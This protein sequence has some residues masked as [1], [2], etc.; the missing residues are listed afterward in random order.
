MIFEEI[1]SMKWRKEHGFARSWD[2]LKVDLW[3]D[4]RYKLR[5]ARKELKGGRCRSVWS[6]GEEFST[7]KD[8][9]NNARKWSEGSVGYFRL[10]IPTFEPK[11]ERRI[12]VMWHGLLMKSRKKS[13]SDYYWRNLKTW[14]RRK[15]EDKDFVLLP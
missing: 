12:E 7:R 4:G 3:R 5:R 11:W 8:A 1:K 15:R 2:K 9:R 10:E 13:K 14:R 6:R